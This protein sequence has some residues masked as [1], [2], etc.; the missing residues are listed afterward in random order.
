MYE[1]GFDHNNEDKG[2]GGVFSIC[3]Q[4]GRSAGVQYS[5]CD[6]FF[7]CPDDCIFLSV[8]YHLHKTSS[9]QMTY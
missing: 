8:L 4:E 3:C 6:D 7:R 9:V 2:R 1:V 5:T